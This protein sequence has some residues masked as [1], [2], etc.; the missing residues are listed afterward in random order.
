MDDKLDIIIKHLERIDRR[1][2]LRMWG[3]TIKGIFGLI[4]TVAF[5]WGLW[6]F[7]HNGDQIIA[8]IAEQAAR[9]AA[10]V[11]KIGTEGILEQFKNL[12]N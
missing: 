11:T 7:Y 8:S 1:D 6:Y 10:E 12:G 9:Q 2:R 5:I 3:S 4:P